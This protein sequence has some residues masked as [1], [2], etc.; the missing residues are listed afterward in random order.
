MFFFPGVFKMFAEY[1]YCCI[2]L[3]STVVVQ[4]CFNM[5]FPTLTS[6]FATFHLIS[7]PGEHLKQHSFAQSIIVFVNA[8]FLTVSFGMLVSLELG[9]PKG[10][11]QLPIPLVTK[12][13]GN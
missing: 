10:T 9:S 1:V 7:I 12:P 3:N 13:N 11:A 6:R 2:F 8:S 4:S 5:T